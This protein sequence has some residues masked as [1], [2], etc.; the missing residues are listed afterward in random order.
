MQQSQPASKRNDV[1]VANFTPKLHCSQ[2]IE[3][4]PPLSSRPQYLALQLLLV[5]IRKPHDPRYNAL[6]RGLGSAA[7]E[8]DQFTDLPHDRLRPTWYLHDGWP[9]SF[10]DICRQAH[11][12]IVE[13]SLLLNT[14]HGTLDHR[15]PSPR[16]PARPSATPLYHAVGVW[17]C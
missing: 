14:L 11:R 9:T 5:E 4:S 6:H 10:S 13:P 15:C 3:T 2:P 17:H 1:Q 16:P 7:S 8:F 12:P